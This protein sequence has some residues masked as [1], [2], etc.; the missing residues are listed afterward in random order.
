MGRPILLA[1]EVFAMPPPT[2]ERLK[3]RCYRCNQLLAVAPSKAG[4]VVACPRCKAE[5]LI[6]RPEPQ[7]TAGEPADP[8]VAG[9]KSATFQALAP[10]TDSPAGTAGPE[11]SPPSSYLDEI[12]ALIP[13]DVAALRPEDLRV[14]GEFFEALTREPTPPSPAVDPFR[15]PGPSPAEEVPPPPATNEPSPVA[16]PS[17]SVTST[18]ASSGGTGAVEAPPPLPLSVPVP[19]LNLAVP[20]IRVEP[21]AI[22]PPRGDEPRGIREV[23]LPASVVL[24]WSLLVLMA[25]PLAFVAGLMVGHFLWKGAP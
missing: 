5:L 13:P 22:R 18:A 6:P 2:A 7:P 21:E 20:P 4:S 19:D 3:V 14:E 10:A 25:I 15:F 24:A 12:A 16:P 17:A 11:G 1:R 9:L 8:S 23:V